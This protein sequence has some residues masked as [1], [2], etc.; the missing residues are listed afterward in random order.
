[1]SGDESQSYKLESPALD[2]DTLKYLKDYEGVSA[3]ETNALRQMSQ[4]F[5]ITGEKTDQRDAAGNPIY[6]NISG[7][8]FVGYRDRSGKNI[9]ALVAKFND[10][11]TKQS[12]T[13]IAHNEYVQMTSDRPGRG[14]TILTP[15]SSPDKKT[16]LGANTSGTVLG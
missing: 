8:E 4:L 14:A 7:R 11:R 6:S 15:L 3:E 10:W 9:D 1:M 12:K 2:A 5:K 13:A 16:V